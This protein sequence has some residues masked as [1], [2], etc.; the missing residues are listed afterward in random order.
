MSALSPSS[1]PLNSPKPCSTLSPHRHRFPVPAAFAIDS[2]KI[3]YM[4]EFQ[5]IYSQTQ[6]IINYNTVITEKHNL[7]PYRTARLQADPNNAESLPL[8]KF[9]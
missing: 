1:Q 2:C 4:S 8:K 9:H 3:K 7:M 5:T 6:H